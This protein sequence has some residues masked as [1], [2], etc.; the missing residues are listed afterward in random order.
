MSK[1]IDVN[2]FL[3]SKTG[4]LVKRYFFYLKKTHKLITGM[5]KLMGSL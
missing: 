4:N 1:I 2:P 3:Y 5:I